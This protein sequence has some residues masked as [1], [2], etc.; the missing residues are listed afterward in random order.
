MHSGDAKSPGPDNDDGR[1]RDE[2]F[3]SRWSRRKVQARTG[4]PLPEPAAPPTPDA[5]SAASP[6]VPAELPPVETLKGLE[7]DY[8]AFLRPEVD[9]GVQRAALKKLFADPHFNQMD[10]LDVYID[11]YS[12]PDPIPEA[13]MKTLEHAKALLRPPDRDAEAVSAASAPPR[14]DIENRVS[15]ASKTPMGSQSDAEHA[16][17]AQGDDASARN[18]GAKEGADESDPASDR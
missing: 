13:M 4:E 1:D 15:P 16:R 7:S 9:G 2:S 14:R 11:D 10:G 8:R 17:G 18:S 6:A 12:L 5:S 3:L